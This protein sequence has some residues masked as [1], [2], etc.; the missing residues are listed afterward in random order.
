ME[1]TIRLCYAYRLQ[2]NGG[3]RVDR[4][5]MCVRNHYYARVLDTGCVATNRERESKAI[6]GDALSSTLF[7]LRNRS[8]S[9]LLLL[10]FFCN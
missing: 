10:I 7:Y 1:Q 2:V 5:E 6:T 8:K 3:E 9:P 4:I